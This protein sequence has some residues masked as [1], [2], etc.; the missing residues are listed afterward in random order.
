MRGGNVAARYGIRESSVSRDTNES[1]SSFSIRWIFQP[2]LCGFSFSRLVRVF[3]FAPRAG[4]SFFALCAF[5]CFTTACLR[6]TFE[7]SATK[8]ERYDV[9]GLLKNMF[10]LPMLPTDKI[11]LT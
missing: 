10:E 6:S 2:A 11:G 9:L 4:F 5:L 1:V 8:S 3:F 7:F